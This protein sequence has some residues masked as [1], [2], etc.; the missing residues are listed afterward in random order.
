MDLRTMNGPVKGARIAAIGLAAVMVTST[1]GAVMA[2]SN[3]SSRTIDPVGTWAVQVTLRDCDTNQP[4]GPPF[5]TLVTLHEGGTVSESAA[6]L[7]FAPGQRT[8]GHGS[9]QR[10]GKRTYDQRFITLILFDT[11]PDFPRT[12]GFF[13]GWSTISS[14]VTFSDADH[15][16]STGTNEF[17]KADGTLY[18]SGCSSATAERFQ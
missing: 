10:V 18:R 3:P 5:N 17:Y 9:W 6:S 15:S 7:A 1:V 8:P 13:A 11:T 4:L 2:G 14:R 12:P 16:T